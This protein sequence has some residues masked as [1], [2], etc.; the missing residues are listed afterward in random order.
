M[1]GWFIYP[2]GNYIIAGGEDTKGTSVTLHFVGGGLEGGYTWAWA[3]GFAM[4]LGGGFVAGKFIGGDSSVLSSSTLISPRL[5]FY[6]GYG[7]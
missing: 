6:I 1:W 4:S 3:N 5:T 7:W 2:F